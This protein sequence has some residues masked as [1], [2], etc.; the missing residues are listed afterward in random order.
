MTVTLTAC[1]SKS[2]V[3]KSR[4]DRSMITLEEMSASGARDAFTAVQTLRPHW[5]SIRGISSIHQQESVKVYLDGSLMGGPDQLRQI[6]TNSIASMRHLSG[7]EASQRYG[8]DH[9]QGAI[10][11]FTRPGGT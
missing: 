11:V 8:L 1:A 7:L 9:G 4:S 10:L 3:D 6:T 5:L 2:G